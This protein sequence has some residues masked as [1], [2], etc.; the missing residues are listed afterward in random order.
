MANGKRTHNCHF[1]KSEYVKSLRNKVIGR[2]SWTPS[3]NNKVGCLHFK[4]FDILP[5]F[6]ANIETKL[7]REK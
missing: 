6:S 1:P 5:E 2:Q 4:D 7:S 3:A